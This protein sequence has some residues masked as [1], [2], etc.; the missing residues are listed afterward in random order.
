[1]TGQKIVVVMAN[2]FCLNSFGYKQKALIVKNVIDFFVPVGVLLPQF[3]AFAV[4]FLQLLKLEP[5]TT[6]ISFIK[7]LIG[8]LGLEVIPKTPKLWQKIG[9]VD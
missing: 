7:L 9:S 3:L 6:N 2:Q 4:G 1:M 8:E 5:Y